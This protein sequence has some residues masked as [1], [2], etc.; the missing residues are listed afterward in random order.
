MASVIAPLTTGPHSR[1]RAGLLAINSS[2]VKSITAPLWHRSAR[3]DV[4][5]VSAFHIR[6]L[7]TNQMEN[8][9]ILDLRAREMQFRRTR[10]QEI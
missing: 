9:A 10:E 1:R 7:S 3:E 8:L 4:P 2:L 5:T 6:Q